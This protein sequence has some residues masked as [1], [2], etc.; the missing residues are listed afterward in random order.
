[1]FIFGVGW[2]YIL[3]ILR[4]SFPALNM[5]VIWWAFMIGF[6]SHLVM[7]S[8]TREGVPWLL[9]IPVKFGV[10]PF[11]EFRVSTGHFFERFI[12]FPG[13]LIVNGYI[14]YANYATIKGIVHHFLK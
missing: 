6:A 3:H 2:Y 4:P 14:Y 9:P 11:K 5:D 10:P 7:D 1:M 8:F 13:L 12:I